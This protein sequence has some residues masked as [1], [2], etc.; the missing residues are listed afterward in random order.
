MMR[1]L[2]LDEIIESADVIVMGKVTDMR[3]EWGVRSFTKS[4]IIYTYI[5]I[6]DVDYIKGQGGRELLIYIPG[7]SVGDVGLG[8]SDA[9][10]FKLGEEVILFLGAPE[11]DG[12]RSIPELFQ[13]KYTIVNGMI[14]EKGIPLSS[15]LQEIKTRLDGR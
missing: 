10:F 5:T 4:R 7:G 14:L 2:S 6:S 15:F 13:G 8:V 9:P 3:S 1:A 11:R 12:A